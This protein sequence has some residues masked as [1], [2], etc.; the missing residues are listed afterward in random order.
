[1]IRPATCHGGGPSLWRTPD[2][3]DIPGDTRE[4]RERRGGN[5][6]FGGPPD[7]PDFP[8]DPGE[9]GE[10]GECNSGPAPQPGVSLGWAAPPPPP[11]C[12]SACAAMTRLPTVLVLPAPRVTPLNCCVP[13]G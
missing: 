5:R 13:L 7:T 10:G 11:S 3:P 9:C 1:M 8:G 4:C 12:S 6:S 2:I